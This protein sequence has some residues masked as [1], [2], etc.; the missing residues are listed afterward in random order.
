M[1]ATIQS[2]EQMQRSHT[3]SQATTVTDLNGTTLL[4]QAKADEKIMT[5]TIS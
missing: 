2:K 3:P 4:K 5:E 1:V